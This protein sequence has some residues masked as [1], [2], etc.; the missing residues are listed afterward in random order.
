MS[1][2]DLILV[3]ELELGVQKHGLRG[4]PDSYMDRPLK[5]RRTLTPGAAGREANSPSLNLKQACLDRGA[6]VSQR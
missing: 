5:R 3:G 2:M 6:E 4:F 1:P